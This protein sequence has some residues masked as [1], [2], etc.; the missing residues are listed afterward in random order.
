MP[1]WWLTTLG[2]AIDPLEA[3]NS[4]G[5]QVNLVLLA[6]DLFV[7]DTKS[8]IEIWVGMAFGP[9]ISYQSYHI[10]I[11]VT[12][13]VRSPKVEMG[14]LVLWDVEKVL[15]NDGVLVCKPLISLPCLIE[16]ISIGFD[17]V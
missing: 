16:G 7:A 1:V 12:T 2:V 17:Q 13:L 5:V 10:L 6:F 14:E 8:E 9:L 3:A 4:L 15:C 11:N